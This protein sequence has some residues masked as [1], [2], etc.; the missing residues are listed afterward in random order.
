MLCRITPALLMLLLSCESCAGRTAPSSGRNPT[1]PADAAAPKKPPEPPKPNIEARDLPKTAVTV[2]G[3]WVEEDLVQDDQGTWRCSGVI[4][5]ES[6]G[7]LT[8]VTSRHC[9]GLEGLSRSEPVGGNIDVKI[10]NIR[11][12]THN[13]RELDVT[14]LDVQ[15][16]LDLAIL[17]TRAASLL[18]DID[19][20]I[21]PFGRDPVSPG[22]SIVCVQ[23]PKQPG[24]SGILTFGHIS[25]LQ[26]EGRILQHDALAPLL[27]G[28]DPV[29]QARG[30]DYFW[31]GVNTPAASTRDLRDAISVRE[32]GSGPLL[33]VPASPEGACRL[34]RILF[35][36]QCD[37]AK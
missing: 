20:R 12:I 33:S 19:F 24:K 6:A 4:R 36:A 34:L 21:A 15:T 29:F 1:P 2:T 7:R 13:G 25:A 31:V 14:D 30:I 23:A 16:N 10:W 28:G 3:N 5:K 17:R 35:H 26:E 8:I 11:I 18:P 9:L 27:E 32:I 37:E 22:D